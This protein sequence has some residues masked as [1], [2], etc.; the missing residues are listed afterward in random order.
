MKYLLIL[1]I[2]IL[3]WYSVAN[4]DEIYL[5]NGGLIKGKIIKMTLGESYKIQTEDGSIF[6]YSEDEIKTIKYDTAVPYREKISGKKKSPGIAVLCAWLLPTAGHAYAGDWGRSS[7]FLLCE[8]AS[9]FCIYIG[10]GASDADQSSNYV[11]F[12]EMGFVAFRIFECID[13]YK[14]RKATNPISPNET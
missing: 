1:I 8:V 11:S 14:I 10:A 5:K 9:I 13:A 12:G 6:V 3:T 7:K 2:I 4:A